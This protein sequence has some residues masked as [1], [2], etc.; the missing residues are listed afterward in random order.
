MHFRFQKLEAPFSLRLHES[1]LGRYSCE[2]HTE[3]IKVIVMWDFADGTMTHR[4]QIGNGMSLA[5]GSKTRC[6]ARMLPLR[7]RGP[8]RL[9]FTG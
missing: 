4:D 9:S 3:Q 5:I 6:F 2:P 8:D 1:D 7:G